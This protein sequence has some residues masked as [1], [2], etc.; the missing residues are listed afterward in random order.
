MGLGIGLYGAFT[1]NGQSQKDFL[2]DCHLPLIYHFVQELRLTT[3]I[4]S[5]SVIN[6]WMKRLPNPTVLI[7]HHLGMIMAKRED[8][9]V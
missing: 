7:P 3:P 5:I 1:I 2:L 8:V 4:I 9:V 6:N